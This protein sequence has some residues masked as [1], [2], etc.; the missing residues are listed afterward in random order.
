MKTLL[1]T[2]YYLLVLLASLLINTATAEESTFK[3]KTKGGFTIE[4]DDGDYRFQLA[5][6]LQFDYNKE[7]RNDVS[8]GDDFAVR[9]ARLSFKGAIKDFSYKIDVNVN[10]NASRA[11]TPTDLYVTYNGWG[12]QIKATAGRQKIGIGLERMSSSKDISALERSALIERHAIS[13]SYGLKFH[14]RTNDFIY[15]ATV[16]DD[17]DAD[18]NDFGYG[19]RLVWNPTFG[20]DILHLGAAYVDRGNIDC[21][22]QCVDVKNI[23]IESAYIKGPFHAQAEYFT[24]SENNEDVDGYYMQLSYVLTGESKTYNGSKGSIKRIKP[25]SKQGAWEVFAR[26]EDG[27]GNYDDIGGLGDIDAS[28][29]GFGVNWYWTNNVRLSTSYTFGESNESDVDGNEF[30]A[31]IQLLL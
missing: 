31:R 2:N 7:Q 20:E 30:R 16:F 18:D 24:S 27:E 21:D 8:V 1:S 3:V 11:G 5:G 25:N 12:D 10:D 22:P 19:A 23:A 29:L 4:S 9:R 6:R 15:S 13:H 26:Y 17:E 28:S 14:G